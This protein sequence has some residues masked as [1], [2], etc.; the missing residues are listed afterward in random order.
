[1]LKMFL[2]FLHEDQ[3]CYFR[4][5]SQSHSYVMNPYVVEPK[6]LIFSAAGL[7]ILSALS[8]DSEGLSFRTLLA[9]DSVVFL[10]Y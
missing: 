1:M 5:E 9:F 8:D 6:L 7:L 3:E 2:H 10:V 4:N